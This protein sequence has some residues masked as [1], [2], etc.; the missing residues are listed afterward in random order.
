MTRGRTL[1]AA[2]QAAQ[3][4]QNKMD[5]LVHSFRQELGKEDTK[6][7]LDDFAAI[8]IA[9]QSDP[10]KLRR[11]RR[12]VESDMFLDVPPESRDASTTLSWTNKWLFKLPKEFLLEWLPAWLLLT[13]ML[14][15]LMLKQ[16]KMV[17]HR[18]IYRLTGWNRDTHVTTTVKAEV[19]MA[20]KAQ[21]ALIG[22]PISQLLACIDAEGKV[23]W[24]A[25]CIYS[26][27]PSMP[28]DCEDP[29]SHVHTHVSAFGD[30]FKVPLPEWYCVKGNWKT[31]EGWSLT[32]CYF[33]PPSSVAAST[34]SPSAKA[35][36]A[37]PIVPWHLFA[38]NEEFQQF[39]K[40]CKQYVGSQAPNDITDAA[41]PITDI[42][43]SSAVVPLPQ[44]TSETTSSPAAEHQPLVELSTPV[45]KRQRPESKLSMSSIRKQI[46]VMTTA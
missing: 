40:G 16:D 7:K 9:L 5:G 23:H 44:P 28:E 30:R 21:A 8:I 22:S 38:H 17:L 12:A 20:I 43:N 32:G 6:E 1:A 37:R 13:D 10:R 19:V 46:K 33:K 41:Q 29:R 14:V 39:W 18:I 35:F 36:S 25:F 2:Q 34:A 42:A 3:R 27:W 31:N 45:K 4:Q 15:T 11:C 26:L 24:D